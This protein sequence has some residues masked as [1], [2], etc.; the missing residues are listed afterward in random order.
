MDKHER[1]LLPNVVGAADI[2][3]SYDHIGGL[4]AVK[5]TLRQC[6]TYPLK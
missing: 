1:A 2:G 5:E 3:V 6:I 4:D